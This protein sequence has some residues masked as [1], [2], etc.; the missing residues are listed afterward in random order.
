MWAVLRTVWRVDLSNAEMKPL[1]SL[2]ALP[3]KSKRETA[4]VFIFMGVVLLWVLPELVGGF[5]PDVAAFLKTAGMA[6]PPMI[7]VIVMAILSFDGKPLLS[8]QEGLQKGVYWPSMFLVGATLSMGTLVTK[9]ELGVIGLLESSLVPVFATL[10]PILVV[11]IFVL[12]AGLQTNVSSNLVTVS[13]VTTVLTTVYA[14]GN[15]CLLNWIHGES[16][17]HDTTKHAICSDFGRFWL[18]EC[19]RC[20]CIRRRPIPT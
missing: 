2:E 16:C 13:V 18:D 14:S 20:L 11:I 4:T 7:G 19:K 6:F 9:P 5:L 12:W 3:A 17:V 8:I 1:E 10:A 15:H